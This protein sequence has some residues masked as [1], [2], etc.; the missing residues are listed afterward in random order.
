MILIPDHIV[1][2]HSGTVDTSSLTW[3]IIRSNHEAVYPDSGHPYHFGVEWIRNGYEILMGRMPNVKGAHCR[4]QR[5]NHRALG[6][7]LVG[8]FD[9]VK[10]PVKQWDQSR[11]AVSYL[12]THFNI[13]LR[14]IIGHKEVE[15]KTACPGRFFDLGKFRS[16]L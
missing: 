5:M 13:P 12:M 14:N 15:D 2:H 1:I 7:V 3:G 9:M 8:N 4:A 16:E 6:F 10:P 11:R